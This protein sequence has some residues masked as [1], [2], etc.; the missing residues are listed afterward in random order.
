MSGLDKIIEH[1]EGQATQAARQTEASARE[2]ADRIISAE[3]GKADAQVSAVNK[4]AEANVLAAN[5]RIQ[6][7]AELKEKRMILEAKQAEIDKVLKAASEYLKGLGDAEYFDIIYKM[8]PRYA[9]GKKGEIC[10]NEKDL[11]R[12]PA[13]FQDKL[14]AAQ[15]GKDDLTLSSTPVKIDGGF[16]LDYGDIEE[17]C[18]F[19]DLIEASKEDLQDK[20]GRILFG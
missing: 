5:K 20:I 15:G 1:I 18:S 7:A 6:S 17:N 16:I 10:F 3:K 12:L 13:D 14:K 2:E 19:D 4:Q 11:S 8:I 9:A